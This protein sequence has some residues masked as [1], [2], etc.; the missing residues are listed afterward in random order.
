MHS[1]GAYPA[2]RVRFDR[3]GTRVAVACDDGAI[4]CYSSATDDKLGSMVKE[5]AAHEGPV[6]DVVF[7]PLGKFLVSGGTD[8]TVKIWG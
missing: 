5:I 3:S 2:N 1:T 7:D 4:R 6:Q 8:C